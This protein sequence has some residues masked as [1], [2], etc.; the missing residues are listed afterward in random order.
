[1][2]IG[3]S[4]IITFIAL[5]LSADDTN[6]LVPG[7]IGTGEATKFYGKEM[8]VTGT[9]AQVSIRPGIIFLNMDKPYPNSPFTLVIFPPDR[10]QFANLPSLKGT[11][12]EASGIITNYH[13]RA[14]MV[15]EKT[16]QLKVLSPEAT[17]SPPTK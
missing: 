15:L 2:R 10:N 1:M 14:E 11:S 8:T 9:V 3:L 5:H 12:I 16:S 13:D 17:N 6:V 7:K 4:V